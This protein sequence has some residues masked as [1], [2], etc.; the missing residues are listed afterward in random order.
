MPSPQVLD[1][2]P[3]PRKEA[4]PLENTLS[5]FSKRSRENQLETQEN[6]ALKDI[7]SQ[8]QQDGKNLEKAIQDIQTRPG[9]SPSKRLN[10]VNQLMEFHKY[11]GELQKKEKERTSNAAKVA[12]IEQRRGLA[13][14]SLN[15]YIDDPKMAEQITREKKPANAGGGINDDQQRRIEH[16]MSQPGYDQLTQAEKNVAL[17]RSG[18]NP[19][20]AK[21][22]NDPSL[23]KLSPFEEAVQKKQAESWQKAHDN[24]AIQESGLEDVK[25]LQGKAEEVR[26]WSTIWGT[27][28]GL[29]SLG[30]EFDTTAHTILEP[31]LKIFNPTGALPTSKINML[32]KVYVPSSDE[33]E[34]TIKGKLRAGVRLYERGIELN[35][36][37][38]EFI[39]SRGGQIS[40]K[41]EKLIDKSIEKQLDDQA[42][43]DA[44][45]LGIPYEKITGPSGDDFFL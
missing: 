18:V 4:S 42:A 32:K 11:N 26:E 39:E 21:A 8:Y 9:I 29:G 22:L 12:D 7:Y 20:V 30:K 3:S 25:W 34:G 27:A 14:G 16:V 40:S 2:S 37:K 10:T 45:E 35:R 38:I 24:L 36:K 41:D 28:T 31:I 43:E 15:A 1:L 13:P 44:K 23:S 5:A 33:S 19:T 17:I 6:D